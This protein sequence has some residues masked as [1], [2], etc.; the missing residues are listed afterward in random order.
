MKRLLLLLFIL[1]TVGL[2]SESTIG[3]FI[4]VNDYGAIAY[5]FAHAVFSADSVSYTPTITEDVY[6]KLVPG[7]TTHESDH[8]T[9]QGDTLTIETGFDGDYLVFISVRASG[10]NQNDVWRIKI[11][12]NSAAL[13]SSVGRFTFRTTSAGFADTRFFFWYLDDLVAGDDISFYITNLTG[14][15]DPTISDFKVYAEQKPE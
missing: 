5:K 15:R 4:K 8:I 13:P 7:S 2:Y 9:A 12:K 11:Y 10:A 3:Q 1:L 6:T 14:S